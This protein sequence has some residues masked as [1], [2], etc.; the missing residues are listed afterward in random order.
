MASS[1]R[2]LDLG[3]NA[4][5]LGPAT[6]AAAAAG[7]AAASDVV[8]GA[9]ESGD[10]KGG[11]EEED[12]EARGV[13]MGCTLAL[14]LLDGV[15]APG[16][17]IC[18]CCCCPVLSASPVEIGMLEKETTEEGWTE[19]AVEEALEGRERFLAALRSAKSPLLVCRGWTL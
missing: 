3:K 4:L 9:H 19:P 10:V 16:R 17:S 15:G 14:L 5:V 2:W 7:E 13:G 12:G 11:E 6:T 8:A 18:R 1:I